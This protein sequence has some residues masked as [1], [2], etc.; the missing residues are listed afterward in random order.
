MAVPT[1]VVMEL[2]LP[3]LVRKRG[4]WHVASCP[5]LDVHSQGTTEREAQRNLIEAL[6]EFLL[7]CFER[8][9]LNQVLQDA[10]FVPIGEAVAQPG[11]KS[12]QARQVRV[13]LPFMIQAHAARQHASV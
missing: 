6:V 8:G 1:Q 11:P 9:T 4:K 5:L 2:L 7:S 10:G 13:P 3:A 12:R